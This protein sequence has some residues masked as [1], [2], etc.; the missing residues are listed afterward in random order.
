VAHRPGIL[1]V[2]LIKYFISLYQCAYFYV[3]VHVLQ[4]AT[5]VDPT[6]QGLLSGNVCA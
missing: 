3:C 2:T 5:P 1:C 6:F 4:V